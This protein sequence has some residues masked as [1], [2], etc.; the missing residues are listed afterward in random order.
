MYNFVFL[1]LTVSAVASVAN[2]K[3]KTEQETSDFES[4]KFS[5]KI[6]CM[7]ERERASKFDMILSMGHR[8]MTQPLYKNTEKNKI[9]I[10]EKMYLQASASNW[11]KGYAHNKLTFQCVLFVGNKQQ[12]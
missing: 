2:R 4:F 5:C 8:Y 3:T 9:R 7:L 1:L 6:A 12:Q 11:V 10:A